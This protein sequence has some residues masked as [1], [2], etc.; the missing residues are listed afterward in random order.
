MSDIAREITPVNIEEELKSSY[1]DYAMSVI[2][3]R[4]LPDV[5]DGLKPVHRR[6]LFAMNVLGNDWNK[7]YKKSA[8]VVGDVIGK[9][10][11]HGDIAVYETIV[12]LAQPFSMRYM[13]VDGQ[14][15]FG[16]VDGDSAAAM[17]YTE[18]RMAKIAHELLADLEKETVDFVPNYDGTE[19]I[20]AVMPTRVPNLL[21][22]GSSGI[23]VG[24]ATNIPP[25]NLGEVING[26]LAYVDNE[27]ITIEELMEHITGPDFPTAAIING[28]RGI[29]DAYRTGRGKI[30]IRAQADIETD[31]KTGRETI[32]VTEIPYQVNKAR[33]IEKIAEL[34][35]DKR[36]EGISGL[37]DES[38]KDG[39]RIVVEIKRDAVGEVVLNHLFSQT[40]MQV[41]FGINMVALHQGQ[42]KLLNLKE[43]ISAFIR[44]RREVV[45]R[46]TIYELR[47]A[48]DRA[49]ILEALAV[50]LANI[51]PVIEMIRQAP[52]PAEAKAALIAQPW[53]LGSV[54][55]MLERAG[56]SNVARPEW[57]E[58]QYG[59]HDGK[60]YLTEQQAQAILDLRLQ[61]L[62][63]LEHE[64]LLDEYRDLL[65]QIAE[66][67]HILRSP[68]RLMEVIRE[69][70]NAIKDQYNDPRR[71][72][73][74]ENTADI[75]IEDLINEENVVV[76]LSHQ[77]YVKY[78]P[79]TDYEAQRRGGKGKSAARIKEEDFID[80]L[81]VANTHDTILCFSSRGRLYWMKVYQLPEASRGARGRPI[82]NLLPLEQ[83]ERITAILPVREYEEGKFVFMATASGT[84]KKTPLQDFSRPRSAGII[85]VNLNEGDELIGVD[86][87]DSTNEVMLFSADGK[88]VRF[89]ED[90]VRPMGRTATGVRG[91]KL[92]D[93]DKVVS[94]IIPRGDGDIL[95][96]TENG[97]GKR[98]AQS[99]Y[100]TKN[101]ATQGVISIKVS[102]RNGKVVGAIQV[103]ETDQIMMITNAGTLVRTR[104]SEVSIVGRNTQGVTL[105]RTTEDELVVGLQRVEDEDDA[106]DDDEVNEVINETSSEEPGSDLANDADEE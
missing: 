76:T 61:K 24:M 67:L 28:R 37:R 93:D 10:H 26:C 16:S 4:A 15:N 81:L 12:R 62:T 74:T 31:E 36:I 104:V 44:H 105:I 39:M 94:L 23:A 5:R 85:A 78:Q 90:C 49:H 18:V 102:E 82:I 47:K 68:E 29:L 33:L 87:T 25:H 32:I 71:T 56:D 84:V 55:T 30:Y 77:G 54:S 22:N 17:R 14:G 6:V 97:Y 57:L 35:K 98:T 60:Y 52:N 86:L 27:D 59:V 7:P 50:A 58:P 75:N 83:N 95:T 40:Q 8:R 64:K 96:V 100:P 66:L 69:E 89:A 53:D 3:G 101:R 1:L 9:Y 41:S 46:R 103:E 2:V 70:L 13:L 38:D 65:L 51:D 20:P 11:P 73:I 21:V 63:G 42:P 48:R 43:I 91:M 79:L 106:L 99:E 92:I 80:R 72:E 19:H 34:V 45:T 88:V